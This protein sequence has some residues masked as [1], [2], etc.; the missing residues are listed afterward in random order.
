MHRS[1]KREL[2]NASQAQSVYL[3]T[4]AMLIQKGVN[5]VDAAIQANVFIAN[6]FIYCSHMN[7][8]QEIEPVIIEEYCGENPPHSPRQ[9]PI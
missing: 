2:N 4:A 3:D 9:E 5:P 7:A 6:W 1:Q 8:P